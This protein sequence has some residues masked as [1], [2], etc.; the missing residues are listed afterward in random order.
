M[1]SNANKHNALYTYATTT[2]L[3]FDI[4]TTKMGK[5]IASK[6]AFN[7]NLNCLIIIIMQKFKTIYTYVLS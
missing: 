5:R 7:L 1:Q 2:T 4:R 6:N 3:S